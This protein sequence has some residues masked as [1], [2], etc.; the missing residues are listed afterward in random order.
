MSTLRVLDKAVTGWKSLI[1]NKVDVSSVGK[2]GLK[3]PDK[4]TEV[5]RICGLHNNGTKADI[6]IFR[7]SNGV[8]LGSH[9]LYSD[10]ISRVIDITKNNETYGFIFGPTTPKNT[11]VTNRVFSNGSLIKETNLFSQM[12]K[13]NNE[14]QLCNT[15]VTKTLNN[16][17]SALFEQEIK[18]I[19]PN[20]SCK[21]MQATSTMAKDGEM[22]L[23]SVTQ[24]GVNL[25]TTNLYFNTG[26]LDRHD[27]LRANYA[28]IVKEK[29]F[30][31]I[32]P[33][34]IFSDQPNT[35][36]T[37][38]YKEGVDGVAKED[39]SS[40]AIRLSSDLYR[41]SLCDTLAHECEHGFVQHPSIHLA[42]IKN[43]RSDNPISQKF[44]DG[45]EQRFPKIEAGSDK[46]KLAEIYA[47]EISNYDDKITRKLSDGT[48]VIDPNLHVN[49]LV[50][51]HAIKAG[52]EEKNRFVDF[53]CDLG[54]E[55][56]LFNTEWLFKV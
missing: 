22:T 9:S 16:N 43:M 36:F 45:V 24:Q 55:F 21:F 31:G 18:E 40:V 25:D 42:R 44:Y 26:L 15:T 5:T 10:G 19:K 13:V 50:E 14:V 34:L 8:N 52:K 41:E 3:I 56:S 20:A 33:P 37:G 35:V 46:Y 6:F 32:E 17:G 29:G 27:M 39:G 7:D 48:R 53:T 2:L 38:L 51:Q 47:D 49:L 54:D 23:N 28:R 12:Y 4:A 30:K 11:I 1:R